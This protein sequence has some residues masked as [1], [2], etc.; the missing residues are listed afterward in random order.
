[1]H[2]AIAFSV[3]LAPIGYADAAKRIHRSHRADFNR[4]IP[5]GPGLHAGIPPVGNAAAEGNN[6]NSMSGSNSAVENAN[7][8]TNCC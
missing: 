4:D 7:G 6:A 5:G 3:A 8:R 1:M 2:A